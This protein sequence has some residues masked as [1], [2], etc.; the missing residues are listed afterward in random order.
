[1]FEI[2]T[3]D[4]VPDETIPYLPSPFTR[5]NEKRFMNPI[6]YFVN[7]VMLPVYVTFCA[8]CL[9]VG[10]VFMS[11]DENRFAWVFVLCMA[12]LVIITAL[13]SW[14]V[15]RT[16]RQ[17]IEIELSRYDFDVENFKKREFYEAQN[18]IWEVVL[19][20]TG[21]YVEGKHYYYTALYPT[22]VTSNH[23][24]RIWVSIRFGDDPWHGVYVPL[25][26]S[27]IRA[28]EEFEIP[29]TNREK[30]AYLIEHKENAFTQI[31][32]TGKFKVFSYD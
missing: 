5:E 3:P 12:V 4:M 7:H 28:V 18:E 31:Y 10:A 15:P 9:G 29:V 1:M 25:D 30:I 22:I 27:I 19:T 16:R 8:L 23:F 17:E 21:L 24:N 6:R 32:N 20:R 2:P 11:V 13:V 26:G 14:Q